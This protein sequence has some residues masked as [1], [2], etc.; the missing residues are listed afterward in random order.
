MD[1]FTGKVAVITGASSGMGRSLAIELARRGAKLAICDIN[2]VGLAETARK[3]EQ[4]S[5]TVKVDVINVA[6]REAVFAW[7]DTVAH[8]FGAVHYVFNNAGIGFV[9]TVERSEFK[10][11]E[12]IM[13]VD[14]WGVVNGTKAFLPH[15]LSSGDGHVINTSSVLGLFSI[16]A[17]SA[18]SSAKFA[19]RGFSEAFRQE[20]LVT[21]Q[22]VKV[23]CVFP[24][25]I[26]TDIAR[27]TTSVDGE[28][29]EA[30]NDLTDRLLRTSSDSA[31]KIILRGVERGRPK[32]LVG[33]DAIIADAVIRLMGSTYQRAVAEISGRLL[34]KTFLRT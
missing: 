7:A 3:C 26:Q 22:P 25:G 28:G 9:G 10:D 27:S 34:P 13:E 32:I 6:E 1:V 18:Y 30:F 4:L 16:P 33:T 21:K 12:R 11:I 20:M 15:L 14:F 2:A 8:H 5:A 23:S 29:L 19:V 31:A 24:G 17:S